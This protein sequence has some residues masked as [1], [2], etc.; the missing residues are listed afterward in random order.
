M[1]RLVVGLLVTTLLLHRA[2][3]ADKLPAGAGRFE[4][5]HA[6]KTIPVWYYLP[7]SAKAGAPV[8]VV[9]HG[10]NRDA[11]RYRDEW[12][13]HAKKYGLL[14]LAPEFSKASFPDEEHYNQGNTLD[15][16]QRPLP[17]EQWSFSF[18]EPVFDRAKTAFGN[19]SANYYLYGH[20]AGAQFVHRFL[21]FV[22]N[23]RVSRAVAANAG[24]WTL[25]DPEIDFPYGLRGSA[26]DQAALKAMLRRPLTVLLG[27]EDTDP[28]DKNLRRTPQALAQG[29]HRYARG[30]FF[31]EAGKKRAA[32][33]GVPLGW[34]LATVP[35]VAHSNKGMAEFAVRHL[36][37]PAPIA[38]RADDRVRILLG[39]DTSGG[40]SYQEQY[41]LQGG[42][43][44]LVEKG[45]EH[46]I[47]QLRRL[48]AAADYR[49]VNLET[50]LTLRRDS[51][52]KT[53]DYLHYSDPVKLPTLFRQYGAV[54]FS[55]ANNHTLDFGS[56]GLDD[57][58]A[59]LAR[60]DCDWFG[61]GTNID[62]AARPLI[63]AFR[64]GNGMVH[65]AV[66]GAFEYRQDYDR[67]F[68]F[69][70]Q[71]SRPGAAPIDTTAVQRAVTQLRKSTPN[72]FVVY[73]VHWGGNYSWRTA[74]QTATA[75]ALR[76]AGVDLIVGHGA[77]AV[78]EIEHDG[79]GWIFYSIGN[80]L[81]NARG[82]YANYAVPPYS[83]PLLLEIATSRAS[84]H[85]TI[86]AYPILSDN[87]VTSYQP[88]FV[89]EAELAELDSLLAEKSGWT[90]SLRA[91]V[92]RGADAIGPFLEFCAPN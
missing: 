77:H 54:A 37:G 44:V 33:L 8:L 75:R 49:V 79:R 21:Y 80:F 45:Y 15:A 7:E 52:L 10:V 25:P 4:V 14:L 86:R 87:Q 3:A 57:T 71:P 38:S 83:L 59:A 53:K 29:A 18:I 74:D 35:G 1:P 90:P 46:G 26:V 56:A 88:R 39:G 42:T 89:T 55:L 23:A 85:A 31:F 64:V 72:A 34:Q 73:F 67:D 81:F 32:R 13:P 43:N 84:L 19:R 30:Q 40:E 22:P 92:K 5:A 28:N 76:N 16:Q 91:A 63:Q 47:A 24:W 2:V 50:P 6:G 58:I 61:A 36:F 66:F 69:Y 17:R 68:Q 78:Q 82:R 20:S 9:M 11:D 48:L 12:L 60:N 65:L 27:T 62:E 51:P 41:A 70:A